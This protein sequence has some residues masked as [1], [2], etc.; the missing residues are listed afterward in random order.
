V[1]K[2]GGAA[3]AA[4]AGGGGGGGGGAHTKRGQDDSA[5]RDKQSELCRGIKNTGFGASP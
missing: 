4:A 5:M 2:R 3:A 1:A